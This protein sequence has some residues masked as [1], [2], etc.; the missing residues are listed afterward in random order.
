MSNVTQNYSG[1]AHAS[2]SLRVL[3]IVYLALFAAS[4]IV[5]I[6]MTSG[7]PYPRPYG[8]I[9]QAQSFFIKFSHVIRIQSFFVFGSAIPLGIFV[10]TLVSRLNFFGIKAAGV[11][12]ALFGGVSSAILL[13]LSGL[14]GWILSVPGVATEIAAMRTVQLWAFATG[15][16]GHVVTLGLF[17]AGIS[18][19]CLMTRL[20]PKWVSWFG[21]VI[22]AICELSA[23]SLIFPVA[24][25]LLPIA[26]FSAFI[27]LIAIGFTLP[28]QRRS[29]PSTS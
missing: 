12:I 16:V 4:L 19:P 24:S 2:P 7:S 21:L 18:V 3:S 13:A 27:W 22:A 20:A 1:P 23:L 17:L 15:G 25:F 26:R 28:K 9:E 14:S 11:Y 29:A 5:M 8:S 6:L 10:A